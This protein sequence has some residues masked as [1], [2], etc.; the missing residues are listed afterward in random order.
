MI[1]EIK[2]TSD[3]FR[4]LKNS[5]YKEPSKALREFFDNCLIG[6][7]L[8]LNKKRNIELNFYVDEGESIPSS[9]KLF[10]NGIGMDA[11]TVETALYSVLETDNKTLYGGTSNHGLG[12]CQ[13]SQYLGDWGDVTTFPYEGNTGSISNLILEKNSPLRMKFNPISNDDFR[14]IHPLFEDG[15][16]TCIEIVN[17][18]KDKWDKNWWTTTS[19]TK[20]LRLLSKI[21]RL[22]LVD[23]EVSIV[24]KLHKDGKTITKQI[25]PAIIPLDNGLIDDSS[26]A[27]YLNSTRNSFTAVGIQRQL[28]TIDAVITLNIGKTLAPS[29]KDCWSTFGNDNLYESRISDFANGTISMNVNKIEIASHKLKKSDREIGFMHLNGL[30]AEVHFPNNVKLP[31]TTIKDDIQETLKNEIVEIVIEESEK[32]YPPNDEND[33]FAWHK[34]FKKKIQEDSILGQ[35]LRDTYFGGIS[36]SDSISQI[37]H[38]YQLGSD[39][40]DFLQVITEKTAAG[41][42]VSIV[43]KIFELKPGETSSDDLA[44]LAKY[45][46]SYPHV[47]AIHI[48]AQSHSIQVKNTLPE[49]N[50][51][52]NTTFCMET[53]DKLDISLK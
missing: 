35:A 5:A 18:Q 34:A 19:S 11:E 45:W 16:G 15:H 7:K 33:E 41:D 49:W 36:A 52:R 30:F 24:V 4:S 39:R 21:Y 1:K 29:E 8:L 13:A 40:P 12:A 44:Q 3:V 2:V 20:Y 48:L 46:L 32:I 10:D 37:K 17:I 28:K 50:K 14:K 23:D 22:L 53:Y 47:E 6:L 26:T 42:E 9:L 51:N 25:E 27:D 31:T 38:E 43:K